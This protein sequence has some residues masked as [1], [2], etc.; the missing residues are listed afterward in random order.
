MET[1]YSQDF[2][3]WAIFFPYLDLSNLNLGD[4]ILQF[5]T[6][7]NCLFLRIFL[8]QVIFEN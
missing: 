5:E 8:Y 4:A 1:S 7:V 3:A 6:S 2:T